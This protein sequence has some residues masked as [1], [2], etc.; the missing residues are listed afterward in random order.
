MHSLSY[1]WSHNY[2]ISQDFNWILDV[3]PLEKKDY[4]KFLKSKSSQGDNLID[5]HILNLKQE[6]L[7][8]QPLSDDHFYELKE[9]MSHA[10]SSR[11]VMCL[12]AL[13][14]NYPDTTYSLDEAKLGE[15]I[16]V[17]ATPGLL[18]EDNLRS[19]LLLMHR[20]NWPEAFR[21][22]IFTA[23][24][25]PVNRIKTIL[26]QAENPEYAWIFAARLTLKKLGICF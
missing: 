13:I 22:K 26:E 19:L 3:L 23:H 18:T 8:G 7:N 4:D 25:I 14:A 10:S 24:N 21:A 16:E 5:R 1:Y 17:A 6:K 9:S 15:I 20:R 12:S 11:G 2:N